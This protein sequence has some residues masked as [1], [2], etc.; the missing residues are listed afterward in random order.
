MQFRMNERP[1]GGEREHARGLWTQP[2]S[3]DAPASQTEASTLA[4][5][6]V[7]QSHAAS[8][9]LLSSGSVAHK[10]AQSAGAFVTSLVL[11]ASPVSAEA[12]PPPSAAPEAEALVKS[13]VVRLPA[14]SDPGVFAAQRTILEAW[15]LLGENFVDETFAGHS[16]DE[17]LK[18][19]MMAA[20]GQPTPELAYSEL[21]TMI[22][23]LGDHYTR[24][25]P[26]EDYNRFR[27]STDGEMLGVG[28][29]IANK[30][31]ESG[32]LTV[33]APIR[34][35]PAER[36]GVRP[37]D[38]VLSINGRDVKGLSG[39]QAAAMLKG[40]DGTVVRVKF[41]RI[42]DEIPG[43]AATPAKP[44]TVQLKELVIPREKVQLSTLYATNL[45][46]DDQDEEGPQNAAWGELPE[47]VIPREKVQLSALY[48]TNLEIDGQDEEAPQ[49]VGYL[50]LA[51][52]SN[53]SAVDMRK[54]IVELEDAGAKSFILDLRN[55]PGGLVDAGINIARLWMDGEQ[56]VFNIEGRM[57][58]QA[59]QTT[60]TNRAAI[61][62]APLVVLVNEYS[63]SASEILAGALHDNNRATVI[64]DKNTYGKGRIQSVYELNDGSALFVTV[65]KY[66]TPAG[67]E[68]DLKG[69]RPDRNCSLPRGGPH[70]F[71]SATDDEGVAFSPG[72]PLGIPGV[73]QALVSQLRKDGC[74]LAAEAVLESEA[75]AHQISIANTS[76]GKSVWDSFARIMM[77]PSPSVRAKGMASEP[78]IMVQADLYGLVPNPYKLEEKIR[79]IDNMIAHQPAHITPRGQAKQPLCV[80]AEAAKGS[81]PAEEVYQQRQKMRH[82]KLSRPPVP[83]FPYGLYG[84]VPNPYKL[85]EKIWAFDN[86]LAHQPSH[87]TRGGQAS[88]SSW[89]RLSRQPAA[90]ASS[91][92][93]ISGFC[94]LRR[95]TKNGL[96]QIPSPYNPWGTSEPIILV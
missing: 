8:D 91:T 49:N 67:T 73:E 79:A 62:H 41:A 16:W 61:T 88:P 28:L 58:Y 18:T 83:L 31:A 7:T 24:R 3:S 20:Y 48:A 21:D 82:G 11:L 32:N 85:E 4:L 25:V 74:M 78:I 23:D 71:A 76:T 26:P 92:A 38:E 33:V 87:T 9:F 57:G 96:T 59:V 80:S 81:S 94:S 22:A 84:L 12:L 40:E 75:H 30:P 2:I 19:H 89:C 66:R 86:K 63:A 37:G 70:R 35:G 13:R 72:I 51:E 54:A 55:N 39:Q 42:S 43:V 27:E 36:A 15:S 52:F 56:P 45:E 68:I 53:T 90:H 47:L 69:I 14:A 5:T 1:Q 64:G 17:E 29:M 95:V 6:G 46:I 50:R 34:G 60:Q 65:A 44:P 10:L 77:M 93:Q